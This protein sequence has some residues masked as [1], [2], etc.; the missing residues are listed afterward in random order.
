EL[1]ILKV[2]L[3]VLIIK[4]RT[5]I[6]GI[7]NRSGGMDLDISRKSVGFVFRNGNKHLCVDLFTFPIDTIG[8]CRPVYKIVKGTLQGPKDL[9]IGLPYLIGVYGN[10]TF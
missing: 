5:F 6:G 1:Y 3:I 4:D 10:G 9:L 2:K 8:P 7:K